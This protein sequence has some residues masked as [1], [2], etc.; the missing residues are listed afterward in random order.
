VFPVLFLSWRNGCFKFPVF[1]IS[2][3]D[4]YFRS[5]L[6]AIHIL[7]ELGTLGT[8]GTWLKRHEFSLPVAW[9]RR[10]TL[11]TG[12]HN[13]CP[14]TDPAHAVQRGKAR[15]GSAYRRVSASVIQLPSDLPPPREAN[16][17]LTKHV[18]SRRAVSWWRPGWLALRH[19]DYRRR[20]VLFPPDA[21]LKATEQSNGAFEGLALRSYRFPA[22]LGDP[23]LKLPHRSSDEA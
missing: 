6:H 18:P 22:D 15:L 14:S 16:V 4:P 21:R 19:P 23:A 13:A 17:L 5:G 2:G 12:R 1:S 11:G 7:Q 8:S 3:G 10:G 20:P 9:N